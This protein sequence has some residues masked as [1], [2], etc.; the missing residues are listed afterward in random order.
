MY[1]IINKGNGKY[2][3]STV[4]AHYEENE[5]AKDGNWWGEYYVVLNESK[6][7]LV[8]HYA[9]DAAAKP[10]LHKMIL[11]T[12]RTTDDWNIDEETR[13]GEIGVAAK[14]EL[15]DMVEQGT[16]SGELLAIDEAYCYE[17]YPEIRNEKD[18][19]NLMVLAGWFHDACIESHEEKDGVLYV[20]FDGIWGGKIEMWF[21][22]DVEYDMTSVDL[23]EGNDPY[24][25][26]STMLIKDG[27]I[28]FVDDA[29]MEVEKIGEG[30]CWFK[31][32]NVKYHAIPDQTN[33][34]PR[35]TA[36]C[37]GE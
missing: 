9:F 36:Q 4:F 6:T 26:D 19:D 33:Y 16:V 28:Y 12:D 20:L 23:E 8:R 13:L 15:L 21:S 25:M 18:I 10:Y 24:W 32:R 34:G 11:I 29:D 35:G 17:A 37:L 1:A 22:G 5:E 3:T 7:A 14:A 31:A 30:Y 2:Y 27:F